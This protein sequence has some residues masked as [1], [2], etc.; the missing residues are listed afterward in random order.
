[1]EFQ[2]RR[3]DIET[4]FW[5]VIGIELNKD[6]ALVHELASAR[7]DKLEKQLAHTIVVSRAMLVVMLKVA[8]KES[9]RAGEEHYIL[10]LGFLCNAG[11]I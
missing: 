3:G 2:G 10:K 8:L 4:Y 7:V 5:S 1:M 6:G 11:I 9:L